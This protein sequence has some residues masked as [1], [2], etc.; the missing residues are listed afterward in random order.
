M[1]LA[2]FALVQAKYTIVRLLQ[3][4]PILK[5]PDEAAVELVG[6]EKQRVTLVLSIKEGCNVVI[7]T[8]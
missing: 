7:G 1:L 3:H 5:L 4:F 8:V 2:D 6:A